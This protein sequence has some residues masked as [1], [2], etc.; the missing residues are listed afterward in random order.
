[1]EQ[2]N[3]AQARRQRAM[4]HLPFFGRGLS[5]STIKALVAAGI[6]Y[7]EQLLFMGRS[8]LS[9]IPRIGRVGLDEIESYRE[10]VSKIGHNR[11]GA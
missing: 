10:F 2:D 8:A 7:P 9:L 11:G 4:Q 1:M 6:E 5:D 3:R